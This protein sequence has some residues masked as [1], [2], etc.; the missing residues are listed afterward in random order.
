MLTFAIS[1]AKPIG[2]EKNMKGAGSGGIC[3][4]GNPF[5]RKP[6]K[7]RELVAK[8]EGVSRERTDADARGTDHGQ[9]NDHE[10]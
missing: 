6:F 2:W 7:T 9:S 5:T 3:E 10:G 4:P 1:E 8:I